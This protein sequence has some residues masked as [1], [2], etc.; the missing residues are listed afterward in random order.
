MRLFARYNRINLAVTAVLLA[1]SAVA[2][3]YVINRILV[4]E[5]DEEL[6]NY[7]L[8]VENYASQT[9]GLPEK[10]VMEDL[11][12][13][14]EPADQPIS[15]HYFTNNQYDSEE[16]KVEPVRQLI[17]TQR[18]RTRLYKV[19]IAKPMEGIH[20]LT[21]VIVF[22]TLGI[23]LIII[24]VSIIVNRFV[25]QKLWKPFYE[26]LN[27]IRRF[28]LHEKTLPE[29]PRTKTEEFSLMNHQLSDMLTD[30][31]TDYR[32]LKEFTENASHEMQ[33]PLAIIR[34]KLDLLIQE[35]S[36]S[37]K[38]VEIL[39]GAYVAIKRISKLSQSLLLL[40]KIEN[41][42]FTEAAAI[43]LKT[44]LNEKM[45]QFREFWQDNDIHITG[46]LETSKI[47]A[48]RELVDILLNNLLA[49]AAI[50]N[51]AGGKVIIDLKK[52]QL[53]VSNTGTGQPLDTARL[54]RRFYKQAQHSQHNGL[55]LSIVKQICDQSG[56]L[57]RYY[58]SGNLHVFALS[59]KE[60]GSAQ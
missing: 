49:N 2:Y 16:N 23:L 12:V 45:E 18:A 27:V 42:Q 11:V 4:H 15:L 36:L 17:Y 47:K 51:K 34:A 55:G 54:F 29:F 39:D 8:K 50:H 31:K 10:G 58:F 9:G 52:D 3:Y 33:T 35:E 1:L 46:H 60:N 14:Y 32:L 7:K 5:L 43:D 19:T 44:T 37:A 28:K 13:K 56:I 38:Q 30:A 59:W 6:D 41:H 40:A 53:M 24:L 22:S 20:L 26:S 48:N 25:L 21:R 57:I